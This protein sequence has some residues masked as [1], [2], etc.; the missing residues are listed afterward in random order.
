MGDISIIHIGSRLLELYFQVFFSI[1]PTEYLV[2]AIFPLPP[3]KIPLTTEAP[4]RVTREG[5]LQW[6]HTLSNKGG[7][8]G[9]N[10]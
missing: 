7:E 9:A 8:L 6:L 4:F 10:N 5:S 1:R 2:P 3:T